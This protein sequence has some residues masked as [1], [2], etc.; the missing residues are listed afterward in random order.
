[1]V[2]PN[3]ASLGKVVDVVFDSVAQPA[4]VVVA[5]ENGS[6]AVPYAVAN[7]MKNEGKIVLDQAR[8]ESAPKVREGEWRAQSG[9]RWQEDA[10]RYW[11]KDER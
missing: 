10:T 7:S 2:S 5:S 6:A 4:F 8:L 9:S 1:M 11:D 3:G